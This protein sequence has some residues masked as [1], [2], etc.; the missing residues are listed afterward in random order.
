MTDFPPKVKTPNPNPKILDR[1]VFTFNNYDKVGK[2]EGE[3]GKKHVKLD[4]F[5]QKEPSE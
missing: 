4:V 5:R 2:W 1:P 3:R